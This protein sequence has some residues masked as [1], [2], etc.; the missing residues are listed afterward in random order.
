[1]CTKT[2]DLVRRIYRQAAGEFGIAAKD[3]I[4]DFTG[5]PRS[6][7]LGLI[8]ACLSVDRNI[9]LMGTRYD[10]AG[11]PIGQLIPIIFSFEPVLQ[12]KL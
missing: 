7:T 12:T 1:M 3:I 9:Q 10:A 5:C 2:Y 8:L 6:M 4:A 11:K